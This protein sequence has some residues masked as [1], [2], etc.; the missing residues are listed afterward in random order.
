MWKIICKIRETYRSLM[1]LEFVSGH[2]YVLHKD[3]SSV[4]VLKCT[5]CGFESVGYR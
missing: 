1:C 2:N 5:T 4:Q 3:E